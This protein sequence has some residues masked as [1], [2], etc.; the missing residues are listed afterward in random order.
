MNW[1]QWIGLTPTQA[2]LANDLLRSARQ[3]GQTGWVYDAAD[4]SLRDADRV[5]S[6]VNIQREYAQAGYLARPGL[7]RKYGAMLAPMEQSTVPRLW[8]LAQTQIFP[9]LRSRYERTIIEVQYRNK[10][11]FPP[12]AAKAFSGQL[13]VVIGYD[14]GQTVSQIKVETATD[15]G[16]SIDELIHRARANLRGLP[17][18]SWESAGDAI[19]KL[20]SAAGYTESFLQLPRT[21][22]NLPAKGQALA[23]I[24]NRGVLLATG[25]DEPGGLAALLNA[26]LHSIRNAPWPLSGDLFRVTPTGS[27]LYIP[28]TPE[29][30]GLATIQKIDMA[31]IYEGQQT[32]LQAHHDAI[33]DDVY[34][35]T[36]SLLVK[37]D[38]PNHARSYCTWTKGISSLLPT[39]DLIAFVWDLETTRKT[40][41]V[42]WNNVARIAGH[43][44]KPTTED[45]PRIRVDAFPTA[46]EL[47]E[48]TKVVV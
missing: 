31:G 6:L 14:H 27:E 28:D 15:W 8:T 19:W 34:V 20:D 36:Y 21:F 10:E 23:M 39:T 48:L 1:R 38:A 41:L 12:R 40:A 47:V 37:K 46:D 24:P 7:L 33:K 13:E 4:S 17:P 45:P 26:A 3:S 35:A 43:Y 5:I 11:P 22:D 44:F 2:D 16:I 30:E 18:P 9:M 42:T 32:A 29:A 25:T